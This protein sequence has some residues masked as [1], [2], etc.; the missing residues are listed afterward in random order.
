MMISMRKSRG[1]W[2]LPAI[3]ATFTL[4]TW[5]SGCGGG[6]STPITQD[7]FCDQKAQKECQVSTKCGTMNSACLSQ[8]KAKCLAFAAASASSKRQFTAANVAACVN[9]TN[10]VYA[11]ATITPA[12]LADMDDVCSYVFQGTSTADCAVKYECAGTKI[13]DKSLCAAKVVKNKGAL[14]G[15][16]GE[17]CAAGSYC[18]HDPTSGAFTCLAKAAAGTACSADV[19][20]VETQRCAAATS[21]CVALFMSGETCGTSDECATTAPYCDPYIG[22]KCDVGLIFAPTATAA[23]ADYGGT[24]TGTGG[25][26][27]GGSGGSTGSNDAGSDASSGG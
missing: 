21:T 3:L 6:S 17:V 12:D 16:P 5:A 15:N 14:C 20:C 11:K 25:S 27:G 1:S 2:A 10:A 19:P 8:R 13:C 7:S 24:S 9:K 18:A 23:C 26:S 4:A 22:N